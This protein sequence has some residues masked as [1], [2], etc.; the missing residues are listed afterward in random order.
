MRIFLFN[1]GFVFFAQKV[2]R[3]NTIPSL[4]LERKGHHYAGTNQK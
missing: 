4:Y 1:L 2:Q 3:K